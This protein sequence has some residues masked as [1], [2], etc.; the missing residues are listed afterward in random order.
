MTATSDN[1]ASAP[2]STAE[3]AVQT[4]L[5]RHPRAVIFDLDG[6]L[7]F[8]DVYHFQ[9]WK[10]LADM[11]GIP[12]DQSA[13]ARLLGVSRMASL[14]VVL[15]RSDKTYTDEEKMALATD[16]NDRYLELLHQMTPADLN[17]TVKSTLD[18][19]RERGYL[20]AVGSS[21]QNATIIL[22]QL[23]LGNYFDAVVDGTMI[24]HSKP[25]PEVF[26]K[27]AEALGISPT[28][29]VVVEDEIGRAHV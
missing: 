3:S 29:C 27:T 8:T 14:E 28:D 24:S 1:D 19:L 2:A 22:G 23:G 9:A 13:N 26:L 12:F 20:L 21:S 11:L 25:S 17:P 4:T 16:K 6:V 5:A 7:C 15:E 18:E 10:E